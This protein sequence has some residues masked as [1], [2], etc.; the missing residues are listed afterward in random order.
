MPLYILHVHEKHTEK[1]QL[2][3]TYTYEVQLHLRGMATPMATATPMRYSYAYEVQLP[4]RYSYT[5]EVQLLLLDKATPMRTSKF[6]STLKS[7]ADNF[8]MLHSGFLF[9][10]AAILK[11]TLN[12]SA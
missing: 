12:Y 9:Y 6:K 11:F 10:M 3:Y 8:P 4:N 1:H 7:I 2:L 5:Y